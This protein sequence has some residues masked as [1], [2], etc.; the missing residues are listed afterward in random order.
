[1]IENHSV[2]NEEIRMT[3]TSCLALLLACG[4]AFAQ[5]PVSGPGQWVDLS[6]AYSE[7]TLYWPTASRFHKETVFEGVTDGGFYYTAYDIRTAEHGGTHVDAPIH[8]FENRQT[9]DQIPL[10]NLI[11]PGLVIDVSDKAAAE[12]D[13]QLC[14]EDI[15]AWEEVHGRVDEGSIVLVKTGFAQYWPVAE[16]YLGTGKRGE[17]AVPLLHFPGIH[18]G[19]ARLLVQRGI[20][21]VGLDTAS[22]DYGQS[23]DF[24]T[25]RI[26]YE[27]NIPGFENVADLSAVPARGAFIVALPMKIEGGSGAPLRIVAFVP[28]S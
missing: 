7:D 11:G 6:H 4:S 1:L 9:V 22:V 15:K 28:E 21:A 14:A 3:R 16:E 23:S 13:Y 27:A 2:K 17:E 25:H 10:K 19:A 24:M 18:P 20:K 26:L 12:P 8:F 5:A